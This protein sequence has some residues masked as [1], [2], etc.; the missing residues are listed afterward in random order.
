MMLVWNR[1]PTEEHYRT[2][3]G[4][5]YYQSHSPSFWHWAGAY[6]NYERWSMGE[7]AGKAVYFSVHLTRIIALAAIVP[8]YASAKRLRGRWRGRA[9]GF[10]VVLKKP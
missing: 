3:E 1:H 6:F 7:E 4:L 2:Y 9:G 10:A 5:P 8:L